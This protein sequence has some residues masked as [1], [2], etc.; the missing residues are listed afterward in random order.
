MINFMRFK[1]LYFLFS[2]LVIVPGIF[3]MVFWGFKPAIDFTGGTVLEL[4][5]KQQTQSEEV[6][7]ITEEKGFPVSSI[8]TSGQNTYILKLKPISKDEAST[9]KS[10][11]A[12]KLKE[13]PEEVRFETVGPILGRELLIKTLIGLA[14]AAS[15]ILG[16]IAWAF[17]EARFGVCAILAMF[18]DSLVILGVY[19]ILGHFFNAEIDVLFVTAVLTALSFSVHDTVIVYDRIR[20]SQKKMT[21]VPFEE[22]ANKAVTETMS[23]SLNNSLTVIFMLLAL[24]LLGGTTIKWFVA[25]LL[26]GMTSGAYSSPFVAVPLL[27]VWEQIKKRRKK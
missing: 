17:K 20:E 3:S 1:Y 16:Y 21:G 13:T 5:F 8:Q 2:A 11:L 27:V 12:N 23:R 7:K 14:L 26:I 22:L 25:A 18:H 24:L 4:K 15:F 19:S 6:K 9:I 10:A